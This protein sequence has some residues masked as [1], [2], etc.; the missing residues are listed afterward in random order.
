MEKK[1][2]ICMA[3][4]VSFVAM[5]CGIS[6]LTA[7][8]ECGPCSNYTKCIGEAFTFDASKSRPQTCAP[9][10]LCYSWDFGDGCTAEGAVVKHAYEKPGEY[11]VKLTVTDSCGSPCG[12]D[13]LTQVVKVNCPPTAVFNGPDCICTGQEATY[14]ASQSSSTTSKTLNYTWDFGDGTTAEGQVVK[15]VFERGGSYRV[16]LTVDDGSCSNC[17]RDSACMNV[18]VNTPPCAEAGN[19]VCMTCVPYD[20]PLTVS[21]RGSGSSSTG[22]LTYMWNFGDGTSGEGRNV[23]HTYAGPGMYKVTLVV[24]DGCNSQCSTASDCLTVNIS[25]QPC[26]DA[27]CDY[28]VCAGDEV[29][30]DASKSQAGPG[31]TYA[32]DFGDGQTGTGVKVSH[33]YAEG[34]HYTATLT[35]TDGE[36]V[37]CDTACVFVNAGPKAALCGPD[38][39]CMG[40]CISF[41]AC[42]SSD[43][44]S[45]CLTYSWDFGDGT[46]LEGAD[47][48]VHH[49][50]DK[51]GTYTVRVTVDDGSGMTPCSKDS[52]SVVVNINSRPTAVIGPCDACCVGKEALF[53]GS[54][55]TDPDGDKLS[56]SWDF[57]DGT[58]AEG[59]K[60]THV[61][62]EIGQY[63]VVLKVDDGKGSPCSVSYACYTA[64]ISGAPIADLC[65]K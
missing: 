19:D 11:T 63:K 23:K 47:C 41:N 13:T 4:V 17:C 2:V 50:Y 48:E 3:L 21:F 31:A 36:C 29:N 12:I 57:G 22:C 59:A 62:K 40:E 58:T 33:K 64:C 45:D 7:K 10:S 60:V 27:G 16:V 49:A 65:V 20:Q 52:A 28:N 9:A 14:D 1:A 46:T 6:S 32:W 44:D 26:A 8:E 15:H 42:G 18:T 35:L 25:R 38:K 24:D 37:S 51:G 53:D 56:Y 5:L 43:P 61:Y 54:A 55:S 34:G 30:F 39:A